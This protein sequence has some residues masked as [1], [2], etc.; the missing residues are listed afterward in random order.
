MQRGRHVRAGDA[1]FCERVQV[2][3]EKR[4]VRAGDDAHAARVLCQP[5]DAMKG[6]AYFSVRSASS[7]VSVRCIVNSRACGSYA[8]LLPG[9][10]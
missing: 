3:M 9:I 1:E 5:V 7:I 10:M 6:F 8:V 2:V 4:T